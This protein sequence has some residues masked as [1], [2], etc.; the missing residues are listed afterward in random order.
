MEGIGHQKSVK[1]YVY[2][3]TFSH[4]T[5]ILCYCTGLMHLISWDAH[6]G[7]KYEETLTLF[8]YISNLIIQSIYTNPTPLQKDP[9]LLLHKKCS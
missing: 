6:L 3:L 4:T 8:A 7:N 2:F 1:I 5:T 9:Y